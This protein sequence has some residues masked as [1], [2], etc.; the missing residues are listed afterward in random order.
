MAS[1]ITTEY[2]NPP[3]PDR[4]HDWYARFSYHDGDTDL[5][6][7]GVTESAAVLSLLTSAMDYDGDGSEQETIVDLAFYKWRDDNDKPST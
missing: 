2:V 7:H 1:E 3:I 4:N 6:G 5:A